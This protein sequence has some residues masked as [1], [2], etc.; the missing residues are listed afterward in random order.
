MLTQL[1][2]RSNRRLLMGLQMADIAPALATF[3]H[4]LIPL[5]GQEH[6]NFAD[7]VMLERISKQ[8]VILPTKT[9]PRKLVFHGSD[10]K[11]YPFL[12]K[13]QEDL[14]LDE[15]IMQLLRICNM[16]LAEKERDWPSYTAQHYSVTPLGSRSG[17]IEWV[18]GATSIFQ[19]YRKW[20]LRQAPASE[21]ERPSE[22]FMKKLKAY[23]LD[24]KLPLQSLADR[25]KWPHTALKNVIQVLIDETPKD[26]LSRFYSYS[27]N[28]SCFFPRHLVLDESCG[29]VLEAQTRGS[30]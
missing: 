8:T 15:R 22:L 25:Q 29:F 30:V 24:N 11:D 14:H 4:R 21:I 23:F 17:L 6:K 18:E 27:T 19:V 7:V 16:M 3:S 28:I 9:R 10:G 13:G 1:S 26:L 12:F 20:Q 5:P 2:S